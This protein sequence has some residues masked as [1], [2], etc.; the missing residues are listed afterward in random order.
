MTWAAARAP[1]RIA[2]VGVL[3]VR[4]LPYR[5][6]QAPLGL[7]AI[8][9]L[10]VRAPGQAETPIWH[11]STGIYG[12]L[13][14]PPGPV[15]LEIEDPARRWLPLAA[16][17]QVPDRSAI[18]DRLERGLTPLPGSTGALV[19]EL[20]MR[21]GPE[22]TLPP[23]STALWGQVRESADS[24]P[25]PGALLGL[26]TVLHGA[27]DRVQTLSGPDG[28]YLLALPGELLDRSHNPPVRR[29]ARALQVESPLPALAAALR[30]PGG[31]VAGLPA[32]L[33]GLTQAQRAPLLQ[34][35]VFRLRL[36]DG[37]VLGP[38][39]GQNPP[40]TVSIGERVRWD[41]ELLP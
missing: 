39:G 8:P 35:R 24:R 1:D 23:G 12:F 4:P 41:I 40:A 3:A 9:G 27:A 22:Q 15:R 13:G 31:F 28:T 2:A 34:S 10:A 30:G 20:G 7:G 33:Y 21:P 38:A 14:L 11:P 19:L 17:A 26:D 16:S 37:S 29:F 5:S 36:A 25:V 32:D 6:D 18:R